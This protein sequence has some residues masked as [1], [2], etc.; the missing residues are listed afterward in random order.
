MSYLHSQ[1]K[2]NGFKKI[3]LSILLFCMVF[4]ATAVVVFSVPEPV[5]AGIP[6][7]IDIDIPRI[8]EWILKLVWEIIKE[9]ATVI[10]KKTLTYFL[11]KIA[12]DSAVYLA[13]GKQ[14]Q[15]PLFW[16]GQ[17]G[18]YIGEV[19]DKAA[20]DALDSLTR[21][22]FGF[23][24]CD[25]P[26][27]V[28]K[29]ELVLKAKKVVDPSKSI[30]AKCTFSEA[31][32]KL[33]NVRVGATVPDL[34][35]LRWDDWSA[36]A[37]YFDPQ[38][39]DFGAVLK[40]SSAVKKKVAE[41][42]EIAKATRE[43]EKDLKSI[44]T[45]ICEEG[46]CDIKTPG[47]TLKDVMGQGFA[48]AL[49]SAQKTYT[50][51]AV[52]DAIGVFVDT[53]AAKFMERMIKGIVPKGGGSGS[54][55][56]TFDGLGV[57]TSL[58][59]TRAAQQLFANFVSPQFTRGET[60]ETLS[61]LATCPAKPEAQAYNNCIIDR[62]F[63]T[64]V[65]QKLTLKEAVE[66]N[67]VD[68]NKIFG[69]NS[70]DTEPSYNNGYPYS[71]LVVLRKYRIIPVTWELAALYIRDIQS[72]GD[73]YTLNTL[74]DEFDNA[75]SPF[76]HLIDPNWVL[77]AQEFECRVQGPGPQIL[78]TTVQTF[79]EYDAVSGTYVDKTVEI[80]QRNDYCA[81]ERSCIVENPDGTCRDYGY[82]TNE[83]PIWKFTG[84][85]CTPEAATCESF[86]TP[87]GQKASYNVN[88]LETCDASQVGC[89]WYS[90]YQTF[91]DTWADDIDGDGAITYDDV[92]NRSDLGGVDYVR[93]FN[94]QIETCDA[95]DDGCTVFYELQNIQPPSGYEATTL[96]VY[97]YVQNNADETYGDY[98]EVIPKFMK[99]A[100]P[101]LYCPSDIN[102][103]LRDSECDNYVQACDA[104]E[105]GCSLYTPLNGDPP[106][107][108]I[109][110]QTDYCDAE[111]VGY[112]QFLELETNFDVNT[113]IVNLIP[114]S[115]A[116][117][118]AE[119]VGCEEFTN[120][121]EVAQGG[122]GTEYFSYIRECIQPGDPAAQVFYTWEGSDTRGYQL[123]TW[124]LAS[125]GGSPDGTSCTLSPD[126]LDCR[127]FI[128]ASGNTYPRLL[129]TVVYATEDCHPYRRSLDGTVINGIKSLS[130]SCP[131]SAVG[132]REYRGNS[133]NVVNILM[134]DDFEDGTTEGWSLGQNSNESVYLNGHSLYTNNN[135]IRKEVSTLLSFNNNY[136]LSFWAK[137]TGGDETVEFAIQTY[138]DQTVVNVVTK[139]DGWR[140]IPEAHAQA[141][142]ITLSPVAG[143]E[144]SFGSVTVG[145]EWNYYRI[146]PVTFDRAV[147]SHEMLRL[148]QNAN[149]YLDNIIMREVTDNYYLVA[150][151]WETPTLC[152]EPF[153]GAQIGCQEYTDMN[154]N[155]VNL[156]GFT[157][158]CSEHKVGCK[159]F[160]DTQN[161]ESPY[162]QTYNTDNDATADPIGLDNVTVPN[163]NLV[164]L[165][166]NPDYYCNSEN[167]GCRLMG[168]PFIDRQTTSTVQLFSD[169]YVLDFPENYNHILCEV[170]GLFCQEFGNERTK[171]TSFYI[172][173]G[174]RLCEFRK[175]DPV[176]G[177][178]SGWYKYET[179]ELCD[180]NTVCSNN[181]DVSCQT[182][183]DCSGIGTYPGAGGNGIC[184]ATAP[185]QPIHSE[186][187]FYNG[188]V[189]ACIAAEQGCS[190]YLD[191]EGE[192]FCSNNQNVACASHA[193]CIGIADYR[194][195]SSD[196]VC[197]PHATDDA[198]YYQEQSTDTGSCNGVVDREAGCRLFDKVDGYPQIY[199][200]GAFSASS[201]PDKSAPVT[202][203]SW[204]TVNGEQFY[205]LN[206]SNIIL[207]VTKDRVCDEWLYCRTKI[208]YE[209]D[210]GNDSYKCFD[211]GLCEG[212]GDENEC[213]EF[214]T[215]KKVCELSRTLCA[216]DSNC[217]AGESCVAAEIVGQQ[218]Q[219]ANI[220]TTQYDTREYS[221]EELRTMSGYLKAGMEWSGFTDDGRVDG[222]LPLSTMIQAGSVSE[223]LYNGDFE[224]LTNPGPFEG[225][226]S[227]T[228]GNCE[229]NGG[230]STCQ[231]VREDNRVVSGLRSAKLSV[232]RSIVDP[233][234]STL[235]LEQDIDLPPGD[236]ILAAYM[237]WQTVIDGTANIEILDNGTSIASLVGRDG[238]SDGWE[239]V[240]ISFANTSHDVTVR[241]SL[242]GVDEGD[243]Y[244]DNVRVEPALLISREH[245]GV[246]EDT[247]VGQDCR[248]YPESSSLECDYQKGSPP[249]QK[250]FT[251]WKGYCIEP[252]TRNPRYCI[253][254]WP[255]DLVLGSTDVGEDPLY[256]EGGYPLYY[257]AE[258]HYIDDNINGSLQ[259]NT[260]FPVTN[261]APAVNAPSDLLQFPR[262][263]CAQTEEMDLGS[264]SFDVCHTVVVA[265]K[266]T[267][268]YLLAI[269]DPAAVPRHLV[270]YTMQ[271][272]FSNPGQFAEPITTGVSQCV[273]SGVEGSCID[274]SYGNNT[275][276]TVIDECGDMNWSQCKLSYCYDA[277]STPTNNAICNDLK[278]AADRY[279]CAWNGSA[280]VYNA[281]GGLI[282]P[283]V[284]T[285]TISIDLCNYCDFWQ[286]NIANNIFGQCSGPPSVGNCEPG[287]IDSRI[288]RGMN[289]NNLDLRQQVWNGTWDSLDELSQYYGEWTSY[290]WRGWQ[291][292]ECDDWG[293][294][295]CSAESYCGGN[296]GDVDEGDRTYNSNVYMK[297]EHHG[298]CGDI[299]TSDR[300]WWVPDACSELTDD[301]NYGEF[302]LYHGSNNWPDGSYV[303]PDFQACKSLALTAYQTNQDVT[304]AG[305]FQRL[306]EG[307][308]YTTSQGY[309]YSSLDSPY[310]AVGPVTQNN[311]P[312]VNPLATPTNWQILPIAGCRETGVSWPGPWTWAEVDNEGNCPAGYERVPA[313]GNAHGG[314]PY[315]TTNV[316]NGL[317]SITSQ[318]FAQLYGLWEWNSGLYK[319]TTGSYT[320]VQLSD[321]DDGQSVTV[322]VTQLDNNAGDSVK[323]GGG[324]LQ[325]D[326]TTNTSNEQLPLR[327]YHVNWG[328]GNTT[329]VTGSFEEK[330]SPADPHIIYHSYEYAASTCG[331]GCTQ[332][333]TVAGVTDTWTGN[334]RC[335]TP[336]VEVWDNWGYEYS[337]PGLGPGAGSENSPYR[338]IVHE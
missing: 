328:D 33:G 53:F 216:S 30:R 177:N 133:G 230:N 166:D 208:P 213:N 152:D 325:L 52:A 175:A 134:N 242:N 302:A 122:E 44:T 298:S 97:S 234:A 171:S 156:L 127:Q 108:A 28:V 160:I 38:S 18:K 312:D 193:D 76:Y 303:G 16:T 101:N 136:T 326:F 102:D 161:S 202:S 255:V 71:S 301:Q 225:W 279:T 60:I 199:T 214:V 69:F 3:V 261:I 219:S 260:T 74:I 115:A 256:Y 170:N 176:S 275:V 241:M 300:M 54:G 226:N 313:Q 258:S 150:D 190:Q 262:Y 99:Q 265:E 62:N 13:S 89:L 147:G 231:V 128:S 23:S 205:E 271:E 164:Y 67:L 19:T 290:V 257:C 220:G 158:L 36:F 1:L 82:C 121:D 58:S 277:P 185:N 131:V 56:P 22:Q 273:H 217:G 221:V 26:D 32:E 48:D 103:P 70:D 191:P 333:C 132:C 15:Q 49:T 17:W 314:L 124:H 114:A 154:G 285:T 283:T 232:V 222:L 39:N 84:S 77:K 12:Y 252:S 34:R 196:G 194:G 43:L 130:A 81:D 106:I 235:Y 182:D 51:R 284:S 253:N 98:A 35:R 282:D 294:N 83:L 139:A 126:N 163:D 119:H 311:D 229:Q 218:R 189:G 25:P 31:L 66:Q 195:G 263:I 41:D 42:T 4:S 268:A 207:K 9:A 248:M 140:M 274:N 118:S 145:A 6:T 245:D 227:T 320:N 330:P 288:Y 40:L 10:Y 94:N 201:T 68:G 153:V 309:T 7:L 305:Y 272:M 169:V 183:A 291:K 146:G 259:F 79:Q 87:E 90:A 308:N 224:I 92:A 73:I 306:Q 168:A 197:L 142:R 332:N 93:Y 14:G 228:S 335:F 37:N 116:S 173:P 143:T 304:Q 264:G 144:R 117:C 296:C 63:A 324:T 111:C 267:P 316:L 240:F 72:G 110:G 162:A 181:P 336:R 96:G 50:G 100:P 266:P 80:V 20:G 321:I 287:I 210:L 120:L 329:P 187:E 293:S 167:I 47:W 200:R 165:A 286:C 198:Y 281:N 211:V 297:C 137:S 338:V 155:Q 113:R 86:T 310:G 29:L 254:W 151:T 11:N 270:G 2:R 88:T 212:V 57:G 323:M 141:S 237:R 125:S 61:T 299:G 159:A 269:E 179:D 244:F 317:G 319:N 250:F 109:A 206:D 327:E 157:S 236:Y 174:N 24:V 188:W 64:A 307:S 148:M 138:A 78:Q 292:D 172:D 204:V 249:Y 203:N 322:V 247:Y 129:S 278:P 315:S 251:G 107:P 295:T 112:E 75:S 45:T 65:E 192:T 104:S 331:T 209:D 5:R 318:I 233:P 246:I 223:E 334:W 8:S 238:N 276:T 27:A 337:Y 149:I 59:G 243:V 178:P 289:I 180:L 186:S 55:G 123:K 239:P 135:Q 280:C 215:P 46:K 184:I 21:T 105:V 91:N 85:S 95:A